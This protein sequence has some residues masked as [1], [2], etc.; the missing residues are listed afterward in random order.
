MSAFSRESSIGSKKAST[1][2]MKAGPQ[3]ATPRGRDRPVKHPLRRVALSAVLLAPVVS[4]LILTAVLYLTDDSRPDSGLNRINERR[5]LDSQARIEL[6]ME[7][8]TDGDYDEAI[9]TLQAV[10]AEEPAND[11]A[12]FLLARSQ[13]QAGDLSGSLINLDAYIR[14]FTEGGSVPEARL[15]RAELRA[16]IGDL[17]GAALDFASYIET[18]GP[19]SSYAFSRLGDIAL[20]SGDESSAVDHYSHAL[21]G[22][23]PGYRESEIMM[24][25]LELLIDRN[26]TAQAIYWAERVSVTSPSTD[27]RISALAQLAELTRQIGDRDSWLRISQQ[28]ISEFP[29]SDA[30]R[31]SVDSLLENGEAVSPIRQAD[32][33]LANDDRSG[34]E[35]LLLS[36]AIRGGP[37]ESAEA[38]F[39]LGLLRELAGDPH[40]ALSW[41][42]LSKPDESAAYITQLEL[43]TLEN[44]LSTGDKSAAEELERFAVAHRGATVAVSAANSLARFYESESDTREAARLQLSVAQFALEADDVESAVEAA[45]HAATLFFE[46]GEDESAYAAL[47]STASAD[48]GSFDAIRAESRLGESRAS[49]LPAMYIDVSIETWLRDFSAPTPS[50]GTARMMAAVAATADLRTAGLLPESDDHLAELTTE[51]RHNP[52]FLSGFGVQ[53][54]ANRQTAAAA[55]SA[56]LLLTNLPADLRQHVPR[57]LG[58]LAYPRPYLELAQEEASSVGLDYLLLY[59]L[60]RQESFFD[61]RAQSSAQA[62][63]LTQIIPSTAYELARELG[64]DGFEEEHLYR[65]SLSLA[66]GAYYLAAQ[67]DAFEGFPYAALAAYNGGPGNADRWG[68]GGAFDN[69]DAYLARIDFDET[70][71]YVRRVMEN[72]AHYRALYL[73]EG[74]PTLPD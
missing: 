29:S 34:A 4:G 53:A 42:R 22:T 45:Q 72:Y 15:L 54:G 33:R 52:A 27:D 49:E 57:E 16:D 13:Y 48:P 17:P 74:R 9:A 67:L 58:E 20:D 50:L 51:G 46:V 40:G 24:K 1:E 61:P 41:F 69:P 55:R 21:G 47:L 64:V 5:T 8:E 70:Y 65:P 18:E 30:A 7:S 10:V 56:G 6:A 71:N 59:A 2:W 39:R 23:L 38:A 25:L 28:L 60:I 63:G 12:L 35:L 32:V 44:A 43:H 31:D 37:S 68:E 14:R 19:A 11:R 3:N 26:D 36:A 66:F 73:G 62:R